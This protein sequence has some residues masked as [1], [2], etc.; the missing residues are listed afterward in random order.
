M[1]VGE[2][3]NY[4]SDGS[5]GGGKLRVYERLNYLMGAFQARSINSIFEP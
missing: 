3:V 5:V 1:N 4:S 2:G